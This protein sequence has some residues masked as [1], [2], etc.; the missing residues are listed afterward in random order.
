MKY[1]NTLSMSFSNIEMLQKVLSCIKVDSNYYQSEM[2]KAKKN[3]IKLFIL[4][5]LG[6]LK[7]VVALDIPYFEMLSN[8]RGSET[9]EN[10]AYSQFLMLFKNKVKLNYSNAIQIN[11]IA[12]EVGLSKPYEI[13]SKLNEFGIAQYKKLVDRMYNQWDLNVKID[14]NNLDMLERYFD[15]V[16]DTNINLMNFRDWLDSPNTMYVDFDFFCPVAINLWIN[17]N[18]DLGN[19]RKLTNYYLIV[20]DF[21]SLFFKTTSFD[22]NEKNL[23]IEIIFE[24]DKSFLSILEG[25]ISTKVDH[26]YLKGQFISIEYAEDDKKANSMLDIEFEDG[27]EVKRNYSL[28]D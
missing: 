21:Q 16:Y 4:G 11:K 18:G 17:G 3:A 20:Y 19:E 5:Y 1:I 2:L 12:D 10:L 22:I 28:S 7:P 23:A 26:H 6:V 14:L 27:I 24:A 25:I 8:T 13:I 15:D 9:P